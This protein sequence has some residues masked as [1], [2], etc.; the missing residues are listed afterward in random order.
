MANEGRRGYINSLSVAVVLVSAWAFVASAGLV[1]AQD[2]GRGDAGHLSEP[3]HELW[4][5][6]VFRT[7]GRQPSWT[8][9]YLAQFTGDI[10][11][12]NP[13]AYV[14]ERQG[15]VASQ[16]RFWFPSVV[17]ITLLDATATADGGAIASGNAET[18]EGEMFSFLAKTD[19]S[20]VLTSA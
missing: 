8:H 13:N 12:G 3:H 15:K 2:L 4:A 20:G 5:P 19:S 1:Q 11:P 17:R 7:S 14:Y 16:A 9:G 10:T 18:D 6:E